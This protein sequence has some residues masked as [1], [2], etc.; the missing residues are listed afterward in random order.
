M[1]VQAMENTVIG[2]A[3]AVS[4]GE[5]WEHCIHVES[6]ATRAA[7][8]DGGGGWGSHAGE[9]EWAPGARRRGVREGS[10]GFNLRRVENRSQ[11]TAIMVLAR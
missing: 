5:T 11:N 3:R 10:R 1:V 9:E 7:A 2:A 8:V 6:L 4:P